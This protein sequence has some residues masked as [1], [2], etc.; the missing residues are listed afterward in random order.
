V[1][2]CKVAPMPESVRDRPTTATEKLF[3]LTRAAKYFYDMDAERVPVSSATLDRER[4]GYRHAFASQFRGSPT[5]KRFPDGKDLDTVTD[6]TGRNLWNWWEWRPEGTD[7]Q[8]F[9]TFPT[10]LP[11]RCLKLGTSERGACPACGAPWRRQVEKN[12]SKHDNGLGIG[13]QT[14]DLTSHRRGATSCMRTGGSMVSSTTGWEPG[15]RCDP[16]GEPVPCLTLDPFCGAGTTLLA[17]LQLGRH[18]VGVELSEAYCELT[19]RRL[20]QYAPLFLGDGAA[21]DA[22][23]PEPTLFD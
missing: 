15:C 20:E 22:G 18:A 17:A 6:P 13:T 12:W 10:W 2:L 16:A 21:A 7:F 11:R 19:A 8:H 23:G 9:A 4:S 1:T 14:K 5:D 3:L